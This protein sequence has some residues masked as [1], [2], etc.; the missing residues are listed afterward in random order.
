[1]QLGGPDLESKPDTAVGI[2]G[3]HFGMCFEERNQ[4]SLQEDHWLCKKK[5]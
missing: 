3:A 4:Q 5:W 1:M 2:A